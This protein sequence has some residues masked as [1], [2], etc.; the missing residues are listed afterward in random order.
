MIRK[1]I[2][3]R[4]AGVIST[5]Y[6]YQPKLIFDQCGPII[7]DFSHS[8]EINSSRNVAASLDTRHIQGKRRDAFP[9]METG[10]PKPLTSDKAGAEPMWQ[11]QEQHNLSMETWERPGTWPSYPKSIRTWHWSM[12]LM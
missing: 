10:G 3:I 8:K 6:S 12:G 1:G 4:L 11:I 9:L 2:K 5:T 7:G